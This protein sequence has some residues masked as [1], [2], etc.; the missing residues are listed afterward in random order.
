MNALR[1]ILAAGV[2]TVACTMMAQ[3]ANASL[4]VNALVGGAPTGASYANFD[5]LALGSAGGT[6]DVRS[7]PGR[8]TTVTVSLPAANP[9]LP[10]AITTIS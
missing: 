6:I 10:P 3:S 2:L 4:I 9:A 7:P 5:N 1:K 8:G